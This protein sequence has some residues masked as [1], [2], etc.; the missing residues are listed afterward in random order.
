M[1]LY[2]FQP[3]ASLQNTVWIHIWK[4]TQA[5]N[6]K[7]PLL[8]LPRGVVYIYIL[9]TDTISSDSGLG[10]LSPPPPVTVS[11][12][13]WYWILP[14]RSLNTGVHHAWIPVR[15][16]AYLNT[17]DKVRDV[18]VCLF[19][20]PQIGIAT[21]MC[22]CVFGGQ[23]DEMDEEHYCYVIVVGKLWTMPFERPGS[24]VVHCPRRPLFP[25]MKTNAPC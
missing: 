8:P 18:V 25:G 6:V 17:Y 9:H 7:A 4:R 11:L 3:R 10:P 15:V 24:T 14:K 13:Q 16:G 1:Y 21:Y 5:L 22:V 23:S 19:L 20:V 12:S 2:T